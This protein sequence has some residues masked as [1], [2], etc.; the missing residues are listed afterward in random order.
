MGGNIAS[1]YAGIRPERVRAV[2]NLEGL[3]LKRTTPAEAPGR[4][5]RW[6]DELT[7]KPR[8]AEFPS[9]ER[10]AELLM[11]KNPR[12]TADR[13]RFVAQSW[14]RERPGGGLQVATD[15]MHRLVNPVLYRREEAEACW[16]ACVAPV[17]VVLGGVSEFRAEL[18]EDASESYFRSTFPN[19]SVVT[20]PDA[21]HMMHH[22]DPDS[23]AA[24]VEPWL[25]QLDG[26]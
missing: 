9:V 17:L 11:R 5:R 18:A 12:L 20:L 10:F 26:P 3:G 7:R 1:L 22:E 6:L 16:R 21:G 8:F 14:S 23:L 13:A 19:V 4:F 25:D 15:P 24:L 2:V